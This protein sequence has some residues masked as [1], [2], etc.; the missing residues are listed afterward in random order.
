M[1]N[2]NK[3]RTC[4]LNH[5]TKFID[6]N[7]SNS[8]VSLKRKILSIMNLFLNFYFKSHP[9]NNKLSMMKFIVYNIFL[10]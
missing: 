5:F 6:L 2:K 7:C 1:D 8:Y 9:Q 3:D 4:M 10:K